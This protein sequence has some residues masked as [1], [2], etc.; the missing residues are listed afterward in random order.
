[1]TSGTTRPER[2]PWRF[3]RMASMVLAGLG[4]AGAAWADWGIATLMQQLARQP[5][6]EARFTETKKLA[7][8]DA[9]L[10]S[11][12]RLLYSPPDRLEKITTQPKAE[13]FTV[14][15]DQVVVVRDGRR[16]EMRL[17]QYPEVLAIVEGI[18]GT[19]LGNEAL[20]R[21]YYDLRLLGSEQDW[22]LALIPRDERLAR[23][24]RQI[25]VNGQR[26]VV[27]SIE[28]LQVDGDS[29]IMRIEHGK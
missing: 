22:R 24:V 20:L 2:S 5:A 25:T 28:T 23:W 10:T 17:Q 19:L 7:L 6:G 27:S 15:Q 26:Q 11:S 16:R 8:L 1:M 14:Q 4:A 21:Q 13:S 9:P 12:G 29:S 18:R 3:W